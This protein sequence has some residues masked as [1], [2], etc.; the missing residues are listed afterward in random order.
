MN[1]EVYTTVIKLN[2][3]E[4]QN[5]LKKLEDKISELKKKKEEAFSNGKTAIGESIAKD[6]NKAQREMK[7]FANSTM[8]T[9]EVLDNLG[10]ANLGQLEKAAKDLRR[11][12]KA[13]SDP[14][15]L[16]KLQEKIDAVTARMDR[17]K[18]KTEDVHD[19]ARKL[20]STLNN[21]PNASANDLLYAKSHLQ[22]QMNGLNPNS[23]MYQQ[24][25]LQL[26]EVDKQ[27]N[28]IK[29]K[30]EQNNTLIA[31]YDR[32]LSEARA[33]MEDV[34]IETQLVNNTLS[35]LSTASVRDLEYSIKIIN[36]QMRGLDRGTKEFKAM[37][38][39]AKKLKTELQNI[40]Y[41]G[42]AQQYWMNR[43]ADWFNKMQ[44][45]AISVFATVTGLLYSM[46]QSVQMYLDMDK[47][48]TNVRKYTGQT[49]EQVAQ[50]NEEFKNMNTATAR[51]QLNK[52]AEDAGRLGLSSTKAVE[53]FVDAADK[54]SVAVGDDLGEGAVDTIAKM[55]QA[56]GEDKRLGLRG[57][58]L[59][60]GSAL[61]EL[62]QSST[63]SAGYIV[64]FT[65]RLSGMG[66]QAKISQQNIM[67][68]GAVLDQ[69]M[70]EAETSATALGQL[71][72]KMYQDPAKF[73]K[74]A[75]KNV[76]DFTKLLKTDANKALLEF[77][78]AMKNRGGFAQLAPMF[79]GMQLNGNR[80]VGVLSTMAA[81][82]NDVKIAQ[83]I[84]NKAYNDGTSVLREFDLQNNS[85]AA[86]LEK[87][88][89]NFQEIAIT[90]GKELL[91][92]SRSVLT[93]GALTLEGL[94]V[95]TDFVLKYKATLITLTA[96]I[97][98]LTIAEEWDIIKK[99]AQALW[100]DV[101]IKGS[102]KLW[103]T[104]AAHPYIAIAAAVA[105]LIALYAELTSKTDAVQ[106][107]QEDLNEIREKA[108]E[109]VVDEKIKIE[110]L[111]SIA[112]DETKSLADR[113]K[114]IDE[115][116][117]IV[118]NYN[119]KLQ[120]TTNKYSENKGALDSYISSLIRLYEIQGAKEKISELSKQKAD[121]V[122]KE[123]EIQKTL[124][125]MKAT[126]GVTYTTSW[127]TVSNT[128]TDSYHHF[129]QQLE[130]V[131]SDI[132]D[133]KTEINTITD[134]YGED[135]KKTYIPPK[136][137]GGGGG[138]N[139]YGND[140]A[141]E[142]ARK[143]REAAERKREAARKKRLNNELK[144]A[145]DET[146]MLQAQNM[147]AYEK[148]EETQRERIEKQHQIAID[149]YNKRINIYKK[150]KEDYRQLED[151]KAKE[152][153]EKEN[154]HN[155]FLQ[156]DI[157]ANYQ[158][159]TAL[160]KAEYSNRDS[161]VYH[162]QAVLNERLFEADMSYMADKL[163]AMKDNSEEWLEL[164]AEMQ[165]R[166]LEHKSDK[167]EYYNEML[168]QYR[169][170]WGKKDIKLQ[171]KIALDGL[172]HLHEVGLLK[173]AEY[174]DMR[175]KIQLEYAL[176]E[177]ENNLQNSKGVVNRKEVDL[178]YQIAHNNAEAG[179]EDKNEKGTKIGNYLTSDIKIFGATWKNIKEMEKNGVLSHEQAMAAMSKATG[180]FAE[181]F[182]AKMQAAY[183]SVST[184]T[185]SLSSYYSSQSDYEVAVTEKK[186]EKMIS[187]AGNN[188]QKTKKLEEQK[189]KEVAKIKT[190]YAH[191]QAS[192]Q[193]AQ[194]IA[195][196]AISAIAA[197]GSAMSG[198]PYPANLVLAP[199][200]AG[201]ALAAGALQ[202]ATIKKQQQAQDAGYYEGGFTSSGR[203]WHKKA[204]I[205]H[206][207]EFVANH[208]AVNNP[209]VRPFLNYIDKA[210]RNN[211]IGGLTA[212]DVSRAMGS[213]T[214]VV[215]AP[216]VNVEN[217]NRELQQQLNESHEVISKLTA[218]LAA[219]IHAK[220]F[221]A[222]DDGI[223][224][225]LEVYDNLMSN[226]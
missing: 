79:E 80:A 67:G 150:Y 176:Q 159:D 221:I 177:S 23:E 98:A 147:L 93:I 105:T 34:K 206:E 5:N 146:D 8:N 218:V 195:Q 194:A 75:G 96:G 115:L 17:L 198:V 43:T 55:A 58:M 72:T 192:M 199:V 10:K 27:L 145:K 90:L 12:F 149:G 137:D 108:A 157:E 132:K 216:V 196:T 202:I 94:K 117:K 51:E 213:N 190:K 112:R 32:E 185:N 97:V 63:A 53:E 25:S 143:A 153:L 124:Q 54:I 212:L 92:V 42:G 142:K 161:A 62:S 11:E 130:E 82:L 86:Q 106:K 89:K 81:K 9:K 188:T 189:E 111:V 131:Q 128:T 186:Y 201:I 179:V 3:E 141:E 223:K 36:Q 24:Q 180:N 119:A 73:A 225:K 219:G 144:A 13:T 38:E 136:G 211:T 19:I 41:E 59:A 29:L 110:N 120:D 83:S 109:Q 173:E 182:A 40:R 134:V 168:S 197:Y 215:S 116:N 207:N 39:Q 148:G 49:A 126:P 167:E 181:N 113:H 222:G 204:G 200:A 78:N 16:T 121:L 174:Q 210:Q 152:E 140:A 155:K 103:A 74:L 156:A 22:G 125:Q 30:Q 20:S 52:F 35:H 138:G 118:P 171:E 6:L 114:A 102:K 57:A 44:G 66:L 21:I 226:K 61:N 154:S 184:L 208:V 165:Q 175:K 129:S 178:A 191:K 48:T 28:L 50:M 104:L 64:D 164:S 70:Q 209:N 162:D 217:N 163:A 45:L 100:N 203:D 193:V 139:N 31:Q 133:T 18:G 68:F 187:A 158:K 15:Q 151:D 47:E 172:D 91:P 7:A 123:K 65:A 135:I 220:V 101:L 4:A 76:A 69:N 71:I 87:A 84:A 14:E 183:D 107:G 1:N 60:T 99:K 122:I 26:R 37:E 33:K 88:K 85:Q 2:A 169:E 170:D 224:K 205:V 95:I 166:E 77:F 160:A 46:R 214:T 56:F 127:G